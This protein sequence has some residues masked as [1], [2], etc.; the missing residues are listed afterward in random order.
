MKKITYLLIVLLAITACKEVKKKSK[1]EPLVAS[2]IVKESDPF[3]TITFKSEDEVVI[4]ADVYL[5]KDTTKPFILLMHQA[6]YSRG[7]YRE[8]AP[9]LNKLGFN[10]IAIDQRS[11]KEVNGVIN[12]TAKLAE[13][14]GKPVKYPD[15]FPDL[16]ASLN[17][18][19]N[20]YKP[21]KLFIWGSSYSAALS[22]VLGAK[23]SNKVDGIITFSPGEYFKFEDKK[24]Q[25]Y[26]ST[27]T[28]PVFVTAAKKE[29]PNVKGIFDAVK[30]NKKEL[31][32][33]K[34]EGRHGSGALWESIPNHQEY[35]TAIEGFLKKNR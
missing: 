29:I 14:L 34:E 23:E 26:A 3:K 17:Y 25:E 18:I 7:E 4:T 20:T 1:K 12:E 35:W 5:L 22:Y 9:K 24:I 2:T 21:T 8:I 6:R 27:I 16:L 33:P 10:C 13:S 31:F 15:A 30:S 11:G 19:E 32:V 28:K